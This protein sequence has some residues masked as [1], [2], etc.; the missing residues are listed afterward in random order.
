MI[1]RLD[2]PPSAPTTKPK[3]D[4]LKWSYDRVGNSEYLDGYRLHLRTEVAATEVDWR[5]NISAGSW[6]IVGGLVLNYLYE[7][8]GYELIERLGEPDSKKAMAI[9]GGFQ[10]RLDRTRV[11]LEKGVD[12]DKLSREEKRNWKIGVDLLAASDKYRRWMDWQMGS[13]NK[14]KAQA[15]QGEILR[16]AFG[17]YDFL[18]LSNMRLAVSIAKKYVRPGMEIEDLTSLGY[19]GLAV[20]AV[21]Y[22]PRRRAEGGSHIRFSTFAHWWVT[23][24][25]TRGMDEKG[26]MIRKPVNLHVQLRRLR[27]NGNLADLDL[28]S[29]LASAINTENVDSINRIIDVV[30]GDDEL[31]DFLPDKKVD[32]EREAI[33]GVLRETVQEVLLDLTPRERRVLSL[34]FGLDDGKPR[35]LEKIGRELGVTR[36][37]IRQI[38]LKA[39]GKLKHLTVVENLRGF[40]S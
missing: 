40:F 26:S 27:K 29:P 32:V 6:I 2:N 9:L 3:D 38:E 37:R 4:G 14:E 16:G 17:A 25:I 21:R 8:Y 36:E 19:L 13:E 12:L 5:K 1:E 18:I 31:G 34:R 20:A 35:S 28:T 24:S 23:Q 30:D 11:Q 7:R 10:R 15:R 39:M 33:A 22:D